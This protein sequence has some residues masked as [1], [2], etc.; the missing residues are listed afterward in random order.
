MNKINYFFDKTP[1]FKVW[2][3]VALILCVFVSALMYLLDMMTGDYQFS[4]LFKYIT[5]GLFSGSM[6]SLAFTS[7]VSMSRKSI[8]FWNYAKHLE[9]M[10]NKANTKDELEKIW[11]NDYNDLIKKCLGGAQIG[12]VK[13]IRAI[14][15]TRI[16]YWK[17]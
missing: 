14:L 1:L 10:I 2:L 15:E 6:F 12:E 4:T 7:M 17:E 5:F 8:I 13:R 16:K 3:I 9:D 11:Y